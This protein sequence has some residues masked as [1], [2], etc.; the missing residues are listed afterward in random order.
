MLTQ[1]TARKTPAQLEEAI[2]LLGASISVNSTNEEIRVQARCLARNFT[3]TLALVQEML[4]RPRWDAAE[5]TRLKRALAT[6]LKGQEANPTAVASQNFF[7]LMYGPNHILSTPVAGTP[8]TT[9]GITL[10]DLKAY[11]NANIS[12]SGAAV[13]VVGAIDQNAVAAALKPLETSWAAKTVSM[14]QQT[15]PAQSL[16]GNVYFID[17]PDA[18][19]STLYIGKLAMAGTNPDFS[20]ATFANALMGNG[21]S[22]R[23]TQLLRIQKGYTYGAYSAVQELKETAPFIVSTSVRANATGPSLQLIRQLLTDFGPT[24][25]QADVATA[26][27]KV[28]KGNTLAY[29]SQGAKLGILRRISKF[30][31]SPKFIEDEQQQLMQ[32]SAADFKATIGKYMPETEL[33]YVVVGD[34]ATQYEEVKKFANGKLTQ[35][36]A[37]GKPVQ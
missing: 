24:F 37:T 15:I 18:K 29:E 25:S 26:Q 36:D 31:K 33:V 1:G 7:K 32:M 2:D 9:A 27:T 20:K 8:E 23:L 6:N 28:V 16:G 12:P 13:H 30:N 17:V 34:K 22:G 4:L 10:D 35:L 14:P 3:P 21:A 11:Y 19:Q 5:F